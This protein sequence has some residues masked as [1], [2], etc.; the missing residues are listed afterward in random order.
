MIPEESPI[1]VAP[2]APITMTHDQGST[3]GSG[4]GSVK[5]D[6]SDML[7]VYKYKPTAIKYIISSISIMCYGDF[8]NIIA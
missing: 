8:R 2:I 6:T 3:S 4:S 5:G 7:W 1:V